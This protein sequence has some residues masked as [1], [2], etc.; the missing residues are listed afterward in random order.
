VGGS[1]AVIAASPAAVWVANR[2]DLTLS[3]I[4]PATNTA[5]GAPVE[6]GKQVDDLAV[7]GRVLWVAGG[8]GTVTKLDASSGRRI[9]EPIS[10]GAAPLALAAD[11]L[12]TWVASGR[13]ER[14]WRIV[15]PEAG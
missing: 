9:G 15:A 1:P 6:L 7:V 4:D 8:D 13:D 2:D 12:G 5:V 3:H 11:R 14:I 10:V